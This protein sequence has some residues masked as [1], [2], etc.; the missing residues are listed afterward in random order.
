MK[1]F[2]KCLQI[3]S[4]VALVFCLAAPD[5][6]AEA[7]TAEV[8]TAE[9]VQKKFKK[10][11]T[12]TNP[13]NFTFDARL[14]NE[15]RWLNTTED[16]YQNLTTF[17]FRAPFAGGKWQF[18]GKA[19]GVILK[20]DTNN[21]GIDNVDESG[22]GDIDLRFMTIPYM[23]LKK[24]SAVALGV[25]FFL[26]TASEDVLGDG[27][28]IIAPLIFYGYFNPFGPGSI[29]VPGYQHKFGI[30]EDE[31]REVHEGLIDVFM[32]KTWSGNQYW[33]FIDP[34]I[35]LDYENDVEFMLLEI[36]GGMMLDKYFGTKG[37]SAYIMPSFGIGADRPYDFSLEV[38]YKIIW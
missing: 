37:H 23:N 17:E 8:K 32:V 7:E 20:T 6:R 33:G 29:I 25:E 38:G 18:R 30:D 34:Q 9:D 1:L 26:D 24:R 31:G 36:Q 27:A 12:G 2:I 15:Y 16:G 35:L 21:D 10:D 3:F 11:K 14:Y 19:R 4:I 13:M 22:F 28:T 5:V